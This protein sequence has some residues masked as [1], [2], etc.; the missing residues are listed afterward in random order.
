MEKQINEK[1]ALH[2]KNIII[3]VDNY[4]KSHNIDNENK[5]NI[6]NILTNYPELKLTTEDFQ[7]K[8]RA[9]NQIP[10][11][12]KCNACRANGEQCSRRKRDDNDYCGTHEKNRP[13]GE[14]NTE[15]EVETYKKIEVWTQEI[16]GII[17]YIDNNNNIY[18][19]HDI[20]SNVINPS[21]IYKYE[22]VDGIYRILNI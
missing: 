20:I 10:L 4:L 16:N 12:L 5:F 8:R 19:T 15:K 17:Y 7:K 3:H 1:L 14:Y 22:C 21:I 13:Y 11:Y 9:K 2:I 18:K 6:V